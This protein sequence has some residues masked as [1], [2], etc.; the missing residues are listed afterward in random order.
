LLHILTLYNPLTFLSS[1]TILHISFHLF[2]FF[3]SLIFI[4]S[5]TLP[6][7][8]VLFFFLSSSSKTQAHIIFGVAMVEV[9]VGCARGCEREV[10]GDMWVA[11][12][13]GTV[14]VRAHSSDVEA[15]LACVA[16]GFARGEWVLVEVGGGIDV[17]VTVAVGFDVWVIGLLN[18]M[19]GYSVMAESKR[20]RSRKAYGGEREKMRERR[21]V[22]AQ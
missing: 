20:E 5:P 21:N 13:A 19:V 14:T 9:E 17:W 16:I 7:S 2:F 15:G 12:G 22:W 18:G 4:F 6:L 10:F 11:I 3:F 8:S 1:F